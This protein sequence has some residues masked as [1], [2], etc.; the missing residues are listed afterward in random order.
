MEGH[1]IRISYESYQ[2]EGIYICDVP[3]RLQSRPVSTAIR[4]AA[5][6]AVEMLLKSVAEDIL[7]GVSD[8][9]WVQIPGPYTPS[10]SPS[11]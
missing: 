10:N 8:P 1:H 3:V 7:K 9:T 2:G 11:K 5:Y 4:E 6:E